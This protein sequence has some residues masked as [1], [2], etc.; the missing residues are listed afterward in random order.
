MTP[1][2]M[3]ANFAGFLV[4][5]IMYWLVITYCGAIF[6][7]WIAPWETKGQL[8]L[9]K[10]ITEVYACPEYVFREKYQVDCK[11]NILEG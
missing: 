7:S 10:G 11:E 6:M 8:R 9:E 2:V 5:N 3:E 4:P 1:L